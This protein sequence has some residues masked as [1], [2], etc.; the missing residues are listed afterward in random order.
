[1]GDYVG[2]GTQN[3]EWHVSWFRGWPH[4]EVKC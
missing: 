3:P 2:D 4:E 1:M